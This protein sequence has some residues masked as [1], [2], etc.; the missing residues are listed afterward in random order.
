MVKPSAKGLMFK[1][2]TWI[3]YQIGMDGILHHY[4]PQYN[5]E[6]LI[7][8]SYPLNVR[9]HSTPP[10]EQHIRYYVQAFGG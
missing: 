2:V 9:R 3:L 7:L 1:L 5:M 4:V 10:L 6:H 8:E